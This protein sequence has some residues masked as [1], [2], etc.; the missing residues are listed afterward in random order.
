M[1]IYRRQRNIITQ[2]LAAM[3]MRKKIAPLR[4]T[5]V[6]E[7][8]ATLQ[9][10][11]K[12]SSN[13]IQL[14]Y[15]R[16]SADL[17]LQLPDDGVIIKPKKF[18][19]IVGENATFANRYG[20][21]TFLFQMDGNNKKFACSGNIMT[22]LY[23]ADC[24]EEQSKT[25][26]FEMAFNELFYGSQLTT[27]PKLPA[28]TLTGRCYLSMFK[29]CTALT[30]APKLPATTLAKLCYEDMFSGCTALTTAPKLPATKLVQQCYA[31]M[32]YK[33][34]KL[35]YIYVRFTKWRALDTS[36]W[37]SGVSETG[38]FICPA[39]L[40]TTTRETSTVPENWTVIKKRHKQTK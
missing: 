34:S 37:L 15:R 7:V 12:Y 16:N 35:N 38:T 21:G 11:K 2:Y 4:I 23:G 13:P 36:G 5:N 1:S 22:L 40:D 3:Q 29:N 14:Y 28:T 31:T 18:I 25:I 9:F 8:E 24:T 26:P 19:E 30:T 27:A 20:I 32:F 33:C 10:N 6:D 17:F 39:E